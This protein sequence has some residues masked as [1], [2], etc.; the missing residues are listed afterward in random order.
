VAHLDG[1]TADRVGELDVL[2]LGH[3]VLEGG[4]NVGQFLELGLDQ[5]QTLEAAGGGGINR[6][7]MAT[8]GTL[9]DPGDDEVADGLLALELLGGDLHAL[10]L[11]QVHVVGEGGLEELLQE[12][13]DALGA[14][15]G[16]GHAL[17]GLGDLAA[18]TDAHL[19]PVEEAL[20]QLLEGA[21][22]LGGGGVLAAEGVEDLLEDIE[23]RDFDRLG[24]VLGGGRL[25][26]LAQNLGEKFLLASCGSHG[27]Q[28]SLV[29]GIPTRKSAAVPP[30]PAR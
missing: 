18:G 15:E 26:A 1:D 10:L 25:L 29:P 5:A 21:V 9:G 23:R 24:G 12:G 3:Q 11:Q 19:V 13:D 4:A 6:N 22:G 17:E 16:L 20:L 30:R 2:G 28:H 14:V 27:H 7:G 8:E